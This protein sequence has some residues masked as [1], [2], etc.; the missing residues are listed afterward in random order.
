MT[1]RDKW[2]DSPEGRRVRRESTLTRL[3]GQALAAVNLPPMTGGKTIG[4]VYTELTATTDYTLQ[5]VI[6]Q[7][8][9]LRD[10]Q[11]IYQT[12]VDEPTENAKW[13]IME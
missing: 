11:Q 10:G 13:R 12:N 9:R 5:E 1:P 8:M 4:Q 3:I 6:D 7:F 2:M